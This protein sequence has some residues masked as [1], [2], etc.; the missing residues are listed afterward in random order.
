MP[1]ALGWDPSGYV[2]RDLP[3]LSLRDVGMGERNGAGLSSGRNK[4]RVG[5][6]VEEHLPQGI[7]ASRGCSI[8]RSACFL[9]P[10]SFLVLMPPKFSSEKE[11]LLH[12]SRFH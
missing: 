8:Q 5:D 10:P 3:F 7:G 2:T 1:W 12:A 6:A 4:G 11:A 9:A